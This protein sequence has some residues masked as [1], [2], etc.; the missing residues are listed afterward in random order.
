[1]RIYLLYKVW[2]P[3]Y[4]EEWDL[5]GVYSSREKAEEDTLGLETGGEYGIKYLILGANMD[6]KLR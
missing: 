4:Y 2:T 6:K 1:M 3:E 5:M